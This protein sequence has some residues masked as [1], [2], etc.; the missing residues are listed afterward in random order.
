MLVNT[1]LVLLFQ[2]PKQLSKRF[3]EHLLECSE[4]S[5]NAVQYAPHIDSSM[6]DQRTATHGSSCVKP[7]AMRRRPTRHYRMLAFQSPTEKESLPRETASRS[8]ISGYT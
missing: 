1:M 8:R 7:A 5:Q 2:L 4:G 6:S 3:S